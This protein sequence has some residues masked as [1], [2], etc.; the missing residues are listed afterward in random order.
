MRAARSH[1]L[2]GRR[3]QRRAVAQPPALC[4]G[5]RARL[6]YSI[7][8]A[9]PEVILAGEAGE[10]DM[11]VTGALDMWSLGVIAVELLTGR[12]LFPP[13]MSERAARN[14]LAGRVP[15]PWEDPARQQ[16]NTAQLKVLRRS[17]LKCLHRDPAQR[18]T[19]RELLGLWNGLFESVTSGTRADYVVPERRVLL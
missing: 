13:L 17:V 14:Q 18:P 1:V 8:Y 9:A 15:L 4:A 5:D 16:E 6:A 19:S 3:D 7:H 11:V 2:P 12:R 10:R